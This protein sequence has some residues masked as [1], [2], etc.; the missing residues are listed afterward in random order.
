M[1]PE[2]YAVER[3][4]AP[5]HWWFEGRR[6][7]LAS[8]LAAA[9][10]PAGARI[11]DVGSG[12]GANVGVLA[13]H[14]EVVAVD[15]SP[16]AFR[17]APA[18]SAP[19]GSAPRAVTGPRKREESRCRRALQGRLEALPLRARS[20]DLV[21]ALDVL[22]HLDDDVGA[23]REIRRVLAPQGRLLVFVPALEI[24]WGLQDEVSEHRRRYTA[25]SLRHT[26]Q[27]AGLRIRRLSYFNTLLFPAV[28]AGRLAMRV[29]RPPVR[30]E[31]ELTPPGMNR[32]LTH[33]FAAEAPLLARVSFPVGVSLLAV[34]G[35]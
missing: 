29:F 25:R 1:K 18:E 15:A 9:P 33:V 28:L 32:I 2:T 5:G 22:E 7:I 8:L 31:N 16:R 21:T 30:S 4:L 27:T 35:R 17:S 3:A 11:L 34:A 23:A 13:S 14:G 6:R 26:L 10:L 19:S 24:L 12:T 20:F